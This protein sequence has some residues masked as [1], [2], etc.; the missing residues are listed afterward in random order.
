MCV[1]STEQTNKCDQEKPTSI[2]PGPEANNN[3]ESTPP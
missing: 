1:H 3:N 2:L